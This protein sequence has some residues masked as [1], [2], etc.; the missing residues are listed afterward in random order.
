MNVI[1]IAVYAVASGLLL[2]AGVVYPQVK[3]WSYWAT[4]ACVLHCLVSLILTSLKIATAAR[5]ASLCC[6][7]ISTLLCVALLFAYAHTQQGGWLLAIAATIGL[8]FII[9]LVM[10]LAL[11]PDSAPR[12]G[13]GFYDGG[14]LMH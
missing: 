2:L 14:N 3:D 10:A 11:V 4:A 8:N 1:L 5:L 9:T 12:A 6:Q 7:S 13:K